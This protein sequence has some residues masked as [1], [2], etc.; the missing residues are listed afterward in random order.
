MSQPRVLQPAVRARRP[1]VA[2]TAGP[3]AGSA[4]RAASVSERVRSQVPTVRGES[5][6]WVIRGAGFAIGAGTVIV[7]ATVIGAALNVVL[8]AFL[9]LLLAAA[10]APLVDVLRRRTRLSRGLAVLAVYLSFFALV[11]AIAVLV[12]PTAVDEGTRVW[13]RIP[14]FLDN[15][16]AWA[17]TLQP[18]I[19][20][21][22]IG[23]VVA[24]ARAGIDG[25]VPAPG[26]GTVVQ[27]GLTVAEVLVSVTTVLVVVAF[28]LVERARLQRYLLAFAPTSRRAG[29]RTRWNRVE[30]RLG[31][32]VRG[33]LL[34]MAV[35]GVA[36]GIAYLVIGLPS[37]VVLGLIAAL[38]EA[39]PLVGPLL[40]AIP[41]LLVATTMGPSVF[42]AVA[43]A[44]LL[45]HIVEGNVLVPMVMRNAMGLSPL[46]VLLSIS[47]GGAVGG[48]AG[49]F[50][51][52]PIAAT[53][54]ILLEPLQD[55][56]VPVTTEVHAEE[57]PDDRAEPES[58]MK[59]AAPP[60]EQ[61]SLS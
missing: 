45:I 11:V 36:S 57:E 5:F 34:L 8:L 38:C 55:R 47:I 33:Q 37:A 48:I 7:L 51:A 25:A 24:T 41:A 35:I 46:L 18:Q 9:G 30:L 21:Q 3:A 58:G 19:L 53:I 22:A 50:L 17:A 39:I 1:L 2:T 43:I 4:V 13:A 28:W 42:A 12:V 60:R 6:R 32:W 59:A 52:I 61:A 14:A 27:V 29:V 20:G 40:G 49:A 31:A 10:L 44:Y 56:E 26:A 54:E 23:S 15:A 16:A